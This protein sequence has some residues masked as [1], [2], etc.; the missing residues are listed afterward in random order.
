MDEG[1]TAVV[2]GRGVRTGTLAPIGE[3]LRS[4]ADDRAL[5]DTGGWYLG[6]HDAIVPTRASERLCLL[7]SQTGGQRANR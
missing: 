5:P 4:M 6:I 7:P 3:I 1:S 2:R